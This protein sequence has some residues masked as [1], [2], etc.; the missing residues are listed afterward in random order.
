[1]ASTVAIIKGN[2][3]SNIEFTNNYMTFL[4]YLNILHD[5]FLILHLT[6]QT[7]QIITWQ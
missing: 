5:I 7:L 6:K 3:Y 1:M 4:R 2:N